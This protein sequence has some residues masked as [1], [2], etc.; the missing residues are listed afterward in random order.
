MKIKLLTVITLASVCAAAWAEDASPFKGDKDKFSYALGMN[1]GTM[2]SKQEVDVDLDSLVKGIKDALGGKTL[3]TE[4]QMRTV[5]TDAQRQMAEKREIKRKADAEV[6]K[7]KA[8][9]FLAANKS[10]EGVTALPSGLQY[11]VISQGAGNKPAATDTV[12]VHY[13]GT[14]TDGTEFDSSYKR[15]Q[16]A[17]FGLSGVIKGWTEGLQIMPAGSKY[18]F[19][20]PPDLAYGEMGRPNI[21]PNSLLIF[22]VELLSNAP[23][24]VVHS[25]PLTSDIIKVPSKEEMDKGA[26]IETIKAEDVE[27]EI[28]KQKQLQEQ[29]KKEAK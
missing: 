3:L 12:T 6:N 20:I 13:K 21:P 29:Q 16:P 17:T 15:G 4:E 19:Y 11:K 18:Q 26:K 9:E 10:K 22:E 7:K 1:Y 25:Q 28:Q 5:L 14:L 27:K 24:P 23:P 2:F 8:D